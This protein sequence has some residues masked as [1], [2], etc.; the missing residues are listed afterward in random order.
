MILLPVETPP[1]AIFRGA[2]R[3]STLS[4]HAVSDHELRGTLWRHSHRDRYAWSGTDQASP[5]QRILEAVSLLTDGCAI[6][7]WAAA[8]LQGVTDLDG[9]AW[10]GGLEPVLLAMTYERRIRRNGIRALRAPLPD[11]DLVEIGGALVTA[12]ERTCFDLMR[13]ADLEGAVAAIDAMLRAGAVTPSA[14][15]DYIRRHA[16]W[17][18][19]PN[20]RT[21]VDLADGR[22]ASCPESRLRV[23]WVVDAGLARPEVNVPVFGPGGWLIGLPDVLD[24]ATGL[25]AEYDGAGHREPRRH[26]ADNVREERLE[27][28]GLTVVRVTAID[29]KAD[30][31]RTIRRLRD[32]HRRAGGRDRRFD[33]WTVEPPESPWL[34]D[35]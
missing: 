5:D 4:R 8:F 27:S 30:R 35:S 18:G 21:A 7:G 13:L 31:S 25:V 34:L 12:P 32:G 20:A 6:G 24:L 22:A 29:L 10:S 2:F 3:R 9:Q 33:R 26:T 1:D 28:H 11:N 17:K 16:G 15:V 19:V 14:M 23:L